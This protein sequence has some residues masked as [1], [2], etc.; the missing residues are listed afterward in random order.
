[1]QAYCRSK[2]AVM[3]TFELALALK[4]EGIL[5]NCLNPGSPFEY[6]NGARDV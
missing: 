4:D 1:M 2:L 6:E 5:V 3:F